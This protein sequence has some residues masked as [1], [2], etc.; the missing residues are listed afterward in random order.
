MG[1]PLFQVSRTGED[2]GFL[3]LGE[4]H[5]L[6]EAGFL[7]ST[8]S[9]RS[10]GQT[11][12]QPLSEL[13]PAAAEKAD[14]LA[15][16]IKVAVAK[17]SKPAARLAKGASAMASELAEGSQSTALAV[18]SKVLGDYL[19]RLREQTAKRLVALRRTAGS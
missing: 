3:P 6:L 9:F 5:T 4:I 7:I 16:R 17:A 8:D 10:S 14:T 15:A 19:P 12:W 11:Q 13:H 18:S 1:E 2:F